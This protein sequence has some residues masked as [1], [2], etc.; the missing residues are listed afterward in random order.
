MNKLTLIK[1]MKLSVMQLKLGKTFSLT[2]DHKNK[3]KEYNIRAG[4]KLSVIECT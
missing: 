3:L 2:A 4:H 1:C